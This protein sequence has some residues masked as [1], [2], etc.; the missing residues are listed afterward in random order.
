[1]EVEEESNS[2]FMQRIRFRS[3]HRKS[4]SIGEQKELESADAIVE[5]K[6]GGTG[7]KAK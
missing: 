5:N 7:V 3:V 6:E 4:N 1:M 2:N